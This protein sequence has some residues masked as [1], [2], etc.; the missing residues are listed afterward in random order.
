MTDPRDLAALEGGS[1]PVRERLDQF[2]QLRVANVLRCESVW[3]PVAEWSARDWA[4]AMMGEAGE[5]CGALKRGRLAYVTGE[6]SPEELSAIGQELADVL[7]YADLLAARL[8]LD[9]WKEIVEKFNAKSKMVGS[10]I[11]L[12]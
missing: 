8:G 10:P 9:L 6:Y 12:A 5:L 1:E 4:F 2:S 11:R 7:I 3:H